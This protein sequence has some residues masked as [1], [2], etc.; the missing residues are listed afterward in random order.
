MLGAVKLTKSAIKSNFNYT[1]YRT[2]FAGSGS[3]DSGNT[4]AQNVVI[5]AV[6]NNSSRKHENHRTFF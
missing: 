1:G 4:F 2:A 3:W 6:D 5:F